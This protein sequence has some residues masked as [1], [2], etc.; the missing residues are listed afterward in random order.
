MAVH[1]YIQGQREEAAF[2]DLA[3]LVN[4]QPKN[5]GVLPSAVIAAPGMQPIETTQQEEAG[6]EYTAYL[7]LY[8]QN[9]DFVG[10]LTMPNTKIDYPV[11]CTPENPEYYLRRAFDGS[12]ATSGTPFV[13]KDA[14]IDSDCFI[15]YGHNMK[16]D[17]MFG[18]LDKYADKTFM[19]ENPKFTFTT[20]AEQREYEVFAAVR[21]RLLNKDESGYRF[22]NHAGTLTETEYMELVGW[23]QNNSL[24]DT[25]IAPQYGEQIILLST[26][27]YHTAN[28]RF[29][30][31]ARRVDP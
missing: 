6:E 23:L 4:E 16:N 24:Y 21:T 3:A 10:W 29:L 25:G 31:A 14:T 1:T 8:E 5:S 28:G 9:Q 18:T 19:E 20:I 30:V 27:S 2:Q 26:C 17:T 22:Y 15:V 12:S 13:G 11:M 7:T